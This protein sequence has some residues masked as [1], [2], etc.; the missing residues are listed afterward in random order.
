RA[1]DL[2]A[3]HR[4]EIFQLGFGLFHLCL[5]L[6]WGILH[7]HRGHI[8]DVGSLSHFFALMEKARLGNHQ[9]DYHTLLAALTQILMAY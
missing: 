4:G 2:N 7:V 9:P 3:W 6:V 5:N 1:K 8:N